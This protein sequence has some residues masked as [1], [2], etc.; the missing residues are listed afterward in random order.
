MWPNIKKTLKWFWLI[1]SSVLIKY[2][3][4]V[5]LFVITAGDRFQ[6]WWLGPGGWEDLQMYG[7]YES[8]VMASRLGLLLCILLIAQIVSPFIGYWLGKKIVGR[9]WIGVLIM[10]MPFFMIVGH[11]VDKIG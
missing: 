4:A 10:F 2:G 9:P 3:I 7:N 5:L 6:R 11:I 8:T 1:V